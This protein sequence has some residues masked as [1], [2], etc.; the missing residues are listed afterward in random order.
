MEDIKK[1]LKEFVVKTFRETSPA[2][3]S[4]IALQ[5]VDKFNKTDSCKT[6]FII[7]MQALKKELVNGLKDNLPSDMPKEILDEVKKG[8]EESCEQIIK[9]FREKLYA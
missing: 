3:A 9:E 6:T 8:A 2:V 5:A 4:F 1:T 7:T